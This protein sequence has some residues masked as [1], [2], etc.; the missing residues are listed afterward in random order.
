MLYLV[1]TE[2][3]VRSSGTVIMA[4]CELPCGRWEWNLGPLQNSQCS[5][6]SLHPHVCCLIFFFFLKI[7]FVNLLPDLDHFT[8]SPVLG[9]V[10][11]ELKPRPHSL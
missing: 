2:E 9:R 8:L 7:T 10:E 5:E 3:G 4:S 6:S 1:R 11:L